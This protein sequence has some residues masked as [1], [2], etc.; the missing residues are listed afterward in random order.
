MAGD[1]VDLFAGVLRFLRSVKARFHWVILSLIISLGLG[2]FYYTTA[3]RKYQS[4]AKLL[5][6]QTGGDSLEKEGNKPQ[7]LIDKMPE[8]EHLLTSDPTIKETLKN[9]PDDQRIDL[10]GVRRDLWLIAFRNNLSVTTMRRTSIMQVSYRSKDPTTAY[11]VVNELLHAFISEVNRMH[12]DDKGLD[13]KLLTRQKETT[14]RDLA[15]KEQELQDLRS[16]SK[17]LFGTKDKTINVLTDRVEKT[18]TAWIEA[19]RFSRQAEALYRAMTETYRTTGDL[20]QYIGQFNEAL[21]SDFLKKQTGIDPA[22]SYATGKTQQDLIAAQSQ[23]EEKLA[24]LGENHPEIQR[25]RK[26]IQVKEQYLL[27]RNKTISGLFEQS[28]RD[29]SPQLLQM[30][31][32]DYETKYALATQ[33]R[34]NLEQVSQEAYELGGLFA[35]IEAKTH[36]IERLNASYDALVERIKSA[37]LGAENSIRA[38]ITVDPEINRS[39]VTPRLTMT[40]FFCLLM[41]T[42]FSFALIYILDM[43]DDRFRSPDDL[44]REIGAPILAMVRK[45]PTL[46]EHGLASLYPFARP[47][48]VESEAFRTLRTAI[49]FSGE[50][51]R[52]LTISSTEPGDGKTTVLASLAVAFAQSGKRTLAIDGDMRRPGLT[53]LFELAGREGL[54]TILKDSR[55]IE[56]VAQRVLVHTDLPNLHLIAAGPKPVNPVEL[57]TSNRLEELLAWAD[58]HYDQIL[59]DAPPSLA[60][61]DV[62][63]IG[64]LVNAA[65]LTV[66]PDENRRR[67]VVRAAESLTA[68]GCNLLGIVVNKL[69][70]K[71]G[72]EYQYGYGY[73]YGDRAGYGY[74]HDDEAPVPGD[75]TI[76]PFRKAA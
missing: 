65:I 14:E 25:L 23:L 30:A 48:S 32:R 15:T 68:L 40:V 59:I 56:E 22:E 57:L 67:M 54:S 47:N 16:Q 50:D 19:D 33:L 61:A 53:K 51:T 2:A 42:S 38:K 45:L 1:S 27:N 44:R 4:S 73:G 5:I 75:P 49:E 52:S 17:V 29:F 12:Q 76:Q 34:T 37:R 62:Q 69:Q 10:A 71:T 39:P 58:T 18:N 11:T 9:L 64:R 74:G 3:E 28:S 55:P 20:R 72:E 13:L 36:E 7:N 46:A 21:A 43:V 31:R 63:I 41:G 60:V 24:Y 66:R 6:L 8:F 70:P 35:E 26:E